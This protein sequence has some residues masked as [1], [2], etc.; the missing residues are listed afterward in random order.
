MFA[1]MP[2]YAPAASGIRS[3]LRIPATGQNGSP[4]HVSASFDTSSA[5]NLGTLNPRVRGSSTWRCTCPDLGFYS[6]RLFYAPDLSRFLARARSCLFGGRMLAASRLVKFGPI[7]LD[8]PKE[9]FPAVVTQR[10]SRRQESR[11]GL[12]IPLLTV[13][14]AMKLNSPGGHYPQTAV[15]RARDR[16]GARVSPAHGDHRL[17]PP[18]SIAG[19]PEVH[20]RYM[21]ALACQYMACGQGTDGMDTGSRREGGRTPAGPRRRRSATAPIA[22]RHG[23]G[24]GNRHP[25][26]RRPPSCCS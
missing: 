14:L 25:Q 2:R 23:V 3:A 4:R 9:R 21:C 10:D 18:G 8:Q 7:G 22:P 17:H 15:C 26:A 13:A 16:T 24:A 12:A 1:R 20:A 11:A 19:P 5:R 6:S